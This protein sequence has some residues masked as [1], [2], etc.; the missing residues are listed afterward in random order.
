MRWERKE[1]RKEKRKELLDIE[2]WETAKKNLA[3]SCAWYS[4]ENH[5]INMISCSVPSHNYHLY[6]WKSVYRLEEIAVPTLWINCQR[7]SPKLTAKPCANALLKQGSV[8]PRAVVISC[9]L[10]AHSVAGGVT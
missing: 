5:I 7:Y 8:Q 10:G 9:I 1:K 4:H 6:F 3:S 2:I